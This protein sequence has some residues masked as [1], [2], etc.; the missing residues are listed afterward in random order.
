MKFIEM[1]RA[2]ILS[3]MKEALGEVIDRGVPEQAAKVFLMGHMNTLT[4]VTMGTIDGVFSG[5]CNLVIKYC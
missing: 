2:S 1:M 3:A 4:A 5:A